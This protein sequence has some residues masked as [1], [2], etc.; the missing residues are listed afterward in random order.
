MP[1]GFGLIRFDG[2]DT[3]IYHL[4]DETDPAQARRRHA[5][6]AGLE[7][8]EPNAWA[9]SPTSATSGSSTVS[10][11]LIFEQKIDLPYVY[12]AGRDAAR[13][14]DR[15]ARGP[16][17][18]RCGRRARRTCRRGPFAPDGTRLTEPVELPSEGVLEAVTVA[19]H[20]DGAPA[21]GLIRLEGAT[22][23]L[24]HRL[25]GGAETAEAGATVRAVWRDERQGGIDDIEHWAPA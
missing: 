23:L 13:R 11:A 5:R 7:R 24:F 12:T 17:R 10:D 8:E 16:D 25:G 18:R 1:Y 4:I 6:R 19:H 3:N 14:A 9:T 22:T 2:A 15:P 20:L 21:Y